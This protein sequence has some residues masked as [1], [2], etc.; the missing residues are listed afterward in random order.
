M[1]PWYIII[2]AMIGFE[3]FQVFKIKS[4]IYRRRFR[5]VVVTG[6][7]ARFFGRL[8]CFS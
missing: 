6:V 5:R 3:S 7:F 8:Q 1:S 4:G 2:H